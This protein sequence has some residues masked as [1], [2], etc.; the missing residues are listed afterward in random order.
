MVF[1]LFIREEGI[2]KAAYGGYS[3]SS[4]GIINSRRMPKAPNDKAQWAK[5]WDEI[6]IEEKLKEYAARALQY[7]KTDI[8]AQKKIN[9]GHLQRSACHEPY[10]PGLRLRVTRGDH[11]ATW[12]ANGPTW[13]CKDGKAPKTSVPRAVCTPSL[14]NGGLDIH[15]TALK[16]ETPDYAGISA[17][18]EEFGA[19]V[20]VKLSI[21]ATGVSARACAEINAAKGG[22]KVAEKIS[23]DIELTGKVECG[24]GASACGSISLAAGNLGASRKLG[25]GPV[26]CGWDAGVKSPSEE[27]I[28]SQD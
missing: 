17:E 8:T 20:N 4:F 5:A 7:S 11:G 23:K 27:A 1:T 6:T 12:H 25:R 2:L 22:V 13:G 15:A 16:I 19:S 14:F 18:A 24:F 28:P 26:V 10:R 9:C 21:D 3:G